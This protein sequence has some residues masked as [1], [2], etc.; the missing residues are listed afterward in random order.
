MKRRIPWRVVA[1]LL[2]AWGLLTIRI[3]APWVG[4]HSSGGGKIH[5]IVR[6][7][8]LYGVAE[9]HFMQVTN[10]GPVTPENR[11]VNVHHPPLLAWITALW[12]VPAGLSEVTVRYVWV[13][14]MMIAAAAFYVFIRRLY[15]WERALYS[16]IF[17]IFSP[18][19]AFFGRTINHG[20]LG[21]G[22]VMPF[23]AVLVNWL[24]RHTSER[25]WALAVLGCLAVWTFWGGVLYVAWLGL[26]ALMLARISQR[27]KVIA[28]GTFIGL[29]FLAMFA[30]YQLQHPETFQDMTRTFLW[31]SSDSAFTADSE[32]FTI[33]QF[34][35]RE[36]QHLNLLATPSLL[37]LGALGF[38]RLIRAGSR[39]SKGIILALIGAGLSYILVFR[40]GA[41]IHDHYSL[42]LAVSLPILASLA[43]WKIEGAK[44]G[45]RLIIRAL[46]IGAVFTFFISTAVIIFLFHLI[47]YNPLYILD[48]HGYDEKII[49]AMTLSEKIAE[50]SR[51]ED[52]VW[53]N[54]ANRYRPVGF[55]AFRNIQWNV[56]PEEAVARAEARENVVYVYCDA[57]DFLPEVLSA[58]DSVWDVCHFVRLG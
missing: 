23:A 27:R 49:P 58:Y 12:A 51:P 21:L 47:A 20:S 28:L 10:E 50:R 2:V 18:M 54:L 16:L 3:G 39:R 30:F 1:L 48:E 38:G 53:L 36:F 5:A 6:N 41:Y 11:H 8:Q 34:I 37:I 46:Q 7:Y 22:F 35:S 13:A 29:G 4:H 33:S 17:L 9:L 40:N 52:E 24:R 57:T 15:G 56:T 43:F 14:S 31:R 45:Q 55:Y 32:S 19:F 42:F 44:M 25:W 26:A